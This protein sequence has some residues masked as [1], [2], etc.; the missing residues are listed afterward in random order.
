MARPA[1]V[2]APKAKAR[3]RAAG[4]A[5]KAKGRPGGGRAGRVGVPARGVVRMRPAARMGG[6]PPEPEKHLHELP[7]G[8]L[9]QLGL[10]L[11]KDAIY[12]TKKVNVVV[13]VKSMRVDSGQVFLDAVGAG[14]ED[15]EL[16][17]A[18]TAKKN[19]EVTIH[20]CQA[21]CGHMLTGETLL[22]GGIFKKVGRTDVAWYTNMEK[23]M[24][25]TEDEDELERMREAAEEAKKA[26]E[27][28][29]TP[30]KDK[31]RKKEKKD[32]KEKK[33]DKKSKKAKSDDEDELEVG[34]KKPAALFSET[35]LDPKVKVRRK[36]LNRARK[37]GQGKKK[38]KK[39]K[40]SGSGEDSS[41]GS[42]SEDSSEEVE[43]EGL[44]DNEKKVRSI[45]NRYPG[46]LTAT[47]ITEART[48]LVTSSGSLWELDKA[49]LPPIM[50]QYVRANCHGSMPPAMYQEAVTLGLVADLML[51]GHAAKA[52]D[53]VSQR[54]KSLEGTSRGS[55]WTVGRQLELARSDH[56]GIVE[57]TESREAA[58]RAK[59]EEKLKA[60]TSRAPA[61]RN[62]ENPN[63]GKGRK[64][65]KDGKGPKGRNE[66]AG[67]GKQGDGRKDDKGWQNQ[68][69]Q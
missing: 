63:Y 34:Q 31:K 42:S 66:E 59:E 39:K 15:E 19:R 69:K 61:S 38:K 29:D 9:G 36:I 16:L 24:D 56:S 49:K 28:G 6:A 43:G 41:S 35:G 5:P 37:L 23:V 27:S 54:L 58:R 18:V 30:K 7:L 21:G 40:D 12:Y 26:R 47:M 4:V 22:H 64:G 52:L 1:A 8:E 10:I 46:A 51:L 62:V 33:E 57:E 55:H 65:G 2:I 14:T 3:V 50:G 67:K 13:D 45:W 20:V 44:F 48:A 32:K 11:L 53:V 17:K 68:K 60:L 25:L